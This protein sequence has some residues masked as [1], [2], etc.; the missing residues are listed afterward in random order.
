VTTTDDTGPG[1]G[2]AS[3]ARWLT[4]TEAA[5]WRGWLTV[6]ELLRSQIARDLQADCG[7]SDPDFSLL[8]HLSEAPGGRIRMTELATALGWSK[9]RLSHQFARMELR[10]LVEREGC[11]SDARSTFAVL[12]CGGRREIE[13]AAP[14]HVDS[15]RRHFVDLLDGRQLAALTDVTDTLRSHLQGLGP[16]TPPCPTTGG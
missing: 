14:L 11:P 12:T 15:V 16:D 10:G 3:P 9:S 4:E 2:G 6:S 1:L 13:H 7:L 8:V 5:A